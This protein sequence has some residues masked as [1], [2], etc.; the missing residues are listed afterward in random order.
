MPATYPDLQGKFALVTGASRRIGIGAA[1]CRAL[2]AQGVHILFTTWKSYDRNQAYDSD[3]DGPLVLQQA[4][5]DS[6]VQARFLEIDLAH[7]GSAAQL[8]ETAE[9]WLGVPDILVNNA[10]HYAADG[11]ERLDAAT[12]DAHYAVNLRAPL[13]L[14]ASR[15][16]HESAGPIEW[17]H[18]Q[19]DF[20]TSL[21]ADAGELAYVATKGAI[22]AIRS[23]L[24]RNWRHSASR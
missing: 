16:P 2:A 20:R 11:F 5:L 9:T 7:P 12:L 17:S 22:E 8:F 3:E 13:L 6:G 18:H 23:A 1:T 24:P 14:S 21:G 10:V 15:P 19:H 4:L